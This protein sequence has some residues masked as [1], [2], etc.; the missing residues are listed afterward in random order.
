MARILVVDDDPHI[1]RVL[2]MWLNR[3]GHDVICALNGRR[4]LEVVER[5]AIDLIISDMNMPELDGLEFAR[6]VRE[7]CGPHLPMIILSAR[8][9]QEELVRQLAS[10]GVPVYPKPFLPSQFVAEIN[11]LLTPAA[12]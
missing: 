10:Y 8:C 9:D 2:L 3:H 4:A 7:K 5:Q 6:A 12:I 1:G 11:R